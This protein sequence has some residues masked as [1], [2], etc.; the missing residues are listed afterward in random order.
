MKRNTTWI[1]LSELDTNNPA[2]Q[3][4]SSCHRARRSRST[5]IAFATATLAFFLT[6]SALAQPD[7]D[8]GKANEEFAQRHFKEA[9]SD[10]EALIHG[11][12]WSANVFYDLGNAY[13]RAG[14]FGRAIL[15][16]ERALA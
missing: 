15:H 4:P 5:L 14:D 1:D 10:Y 11:G 3:P 7:A 13:F 2:A 9:I 6:M 8:F 12:Q 16:Y